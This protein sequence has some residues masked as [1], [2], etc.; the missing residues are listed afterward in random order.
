MYVCVNI[1][2]CVCMYV[3]MYVCILVYRYIHTVHLHIQYHKIIFLSP[4]DMPCA[5]SFILRPNLAEP[6][7]REW[8]DYYLPSKNF[9]Q[10]HEQV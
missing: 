5:G 10:F 8:W 3:C 2:M 9:K 4:E 7:L 1:Y 6:V